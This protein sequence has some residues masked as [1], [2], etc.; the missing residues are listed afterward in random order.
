MLL[1]T[2]QMDTLAADNSHRHAHL[3]SLVATVSF[4][5]SNII[6]IDGSSTMCAAAAGQRRHNNSD[7]PH[8]MAQHTAAITEKLRLQ[9]VRK[10][11]GTSLGHQYRVL[12][13][14]ASSTTDGCIASSRLPHCLTLY[15]T[16]VA[17]SCCGVAA[18]QCD[19]ISQRCV[20]VDGK[21][22][23]NVCHRNAERI[24]TTRHG[25]HTV[26]QHWA[27]A[28]F[29][30]YHFSGRGIRLFRPKCYCA[31]MWMWGNTQHAHAML[32]M[33]FFRMMRTCWSCN[34][35]RPDTI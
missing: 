19:T 4:V 29:Y 3:H 1:T 20:N 33:Q 27:R 22:R 26:M 13:M 18:W 30:C 6:Y 2:G 11:T 24:V 12:L 14:M 25:Q 32:S 34:N 9:S 16:Y 7:R 17:C 28:W 31:G 10:R 5:R 23:I 35:A 21:V 8:C 15:S